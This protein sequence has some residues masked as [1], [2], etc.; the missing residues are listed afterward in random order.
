MMRVVLRA[1]GALWALAVLAPVAQS[2][3]AISG[4]VNSV[5]CAGA[6][7]C[8]AVGSAPSP[9][10]GPQVAVIERWN[11]SSW[12][13]QSTP[14]IGSPSVVLNGVSCSS[15]HACLAVGRAGDQ[16]LALRYANG[17][18]A[19]LP[20]PGVPGAT[21]GE[22]A[23][24][25]C[26]SASNCVA[27]GNASGSGAFG[28]TSLAMHWNGRSWSIQPTPNPS[29]QPSSGIGGQDVAL[30]DVWCGSGKTCIAVGS[31]STTDY[32]TIKTYDLTLRWDGKRWAIQ[33]KM[34][35]PGWSSLACSSA[36]SC[37]A[38]GNGP[39]A[40]WNGRG[41]RSQRVPHLKGFNLTALNAVS[42]SSSDACM[43][44]G[45]AGQQV[46]VAERWN[47]KKWSISALPTPPQLKGI[48]SSGTA[49]ACATRQTCLAFLTGTLATLDFGNVEMTGSDR[50]KSGRWT[51][52]SFPSPA[53]L[54]V[55][56]QSRLAGDS[57]VAANA[58][59]A[60][61]SVSYGGREL[62]LAESWNGTSWTI[63]PGA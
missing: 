49:V 61:G 26:R 38:T 39:L 9:G 46:P 33:T 13:P 17:T 43:A 63:Q 62:T 25:W 32:H 1:V 41:W 44:V 18:W 34:S 24:V 42:C 54:I 28:A 53:G 30:N 50:W 36:K 15:T 29:F 57:C 59:T 31:V 20:T 16:T 23:G 2:Q 22:L 35:G 56:P 4:T 7:A 11:G 6:K 37:L 19:V 51:S 40:R 45:R 60:V 14:V 12:R 58:C 27:V 5:S 48:R 8:V 55:T 21:Q 52:Q 10:S 3:A 47:G